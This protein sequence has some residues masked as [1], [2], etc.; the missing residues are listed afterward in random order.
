LQRIEGKQPVQT[1]RDLQTA[2]RGYTHELDLAARFPRVDVVQHG[3]AE[4]LQIQGSAN[5]E[6]A[7][8]A[9]LR[10]GTLAG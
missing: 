8:A 9:A 3:V 10:A 7:H 1:I 6:L 2:E 4:K 5:G